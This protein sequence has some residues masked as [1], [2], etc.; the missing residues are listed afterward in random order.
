M[1][2]PPPSGCA[3]LFIALGVVLAPR[4][5][6]AEAPAVATPPGRYTPYIERGNAV[7]APFA[8]AQPGVIATLRPGAPTLVEGSVGF[9]VGLT[10]RV[11]LDGAIGTLAMAPRVGFHSLQIGP[12]ALL[13]DIPAF[14]L[15]ATA[16]VSFAAVDGRPVEQVEPGLMAVVRPGP[17]LRV[18]AGLYV[19]GNPGPVTTFGLRVPLS[20]TLQITPHVYAAIN[21]GVTVATFADLAGTTAIPVGLTLGWGERLGRAPRPVAVAVVPSIVFPELIKPWAAATL[22]P[23]YAAIALTFIVGSRL[24]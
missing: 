4:A 10:S 23:G 20:L 5:A 15:A 19:D 17:P 9:G 18:D 16:H 8:Y 22:R 11:W 1:R 13:V 3:A 2:A 14:E 21:S 6:S 24:W 12:N 7:P